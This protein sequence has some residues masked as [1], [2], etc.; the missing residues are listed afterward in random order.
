MLK[1]QEIANQIEEYIRVSKLEQGEKL[2][3]L[4]DLIT[5]YEVSKNTVIKALSILEKKWRH[6]SSTWE[7]Y[8]CKTPKS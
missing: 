4:E 3:S 1:Y 8:F 2:P 5:N 7:W 6:L